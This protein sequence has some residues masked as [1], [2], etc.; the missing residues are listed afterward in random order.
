MGGALSQRRSGRVIVIVLTYRGA[1]IA[2]ECL[3]S[4]LESSYPDFRIIVLDNASPDGTYAR[5]K[6]WAGGASPLPIADSPIGA[7]ANAK[8]PLDYAER[9][10]DEAP[11]DTASLPAVTLVQ[12]GANLGYA[13]GNNV[14]LKWLQQLTDWDYAW[15]LNPDTVIARDAMSALAKKCASDPSLG[16]VGARITF[17][18]RPEII[19]QWGGA[20]HRPLRGT[21]RL[22]GLGHS[23]A[24]SVDEARIET[25]MDF[26][27][28]AAMFLTPEFLCRAGTMDE[29]YFLYFEE[30]DWC[31]RRGDLRLGYA[32]E[33]QVYHR[34]GSSIGSSNS[35]RKMSPLSISWSLRNRFRFARKFYPR[36]LPVIYLTS[37]ID[38]ARMLSQGAFGNA[39]LEFKLLN[40]IMP[41][42][43][44]PAR[45]AVKRGAAAG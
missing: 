34:L 32:H 6:E 33:A 38:I 12:T 19:Q 39:W 10:P 23:A 31:R 40:G 11:H 2:I 36:A 43:E 25:E 37:Y 13:G 7:K 17:Y 8:G 28:G 29:D 3:W 24:E 16:V 5:I 35:Y 27:S 14:A 9:R 42:P 18:D 4:V 21:G 15:I 1:D 44:P 22:L 30:A 26:V 41:F 20:E 45:D